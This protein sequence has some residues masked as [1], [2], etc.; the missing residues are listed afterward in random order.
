MRTPRGFS[1][2]IIFSFILIFVL[3]S[4]GGSVTEEEANNILK[5]QLALTNEDCSTAVDILEGMGRKTDNLDYIQT[6]SSAY[7][8]YT[9]FRETT[10]WTSD[11]A[12]IDASSTVN[13]F[14]S[15]VTF[16]TSA[17]MTSAT[18]SRHSNLVTA[19]E[20][21]LLAGGALTTSSHSNRLAIYGETGAQNINLQSLFMMLAQMGKYLQYYGNGNISTGS[22]GGGNPNGATNN[23]FYQYTGD[24]RT[25]LGTITA[26]PCVQDEAGSTDLTG[27]GT[28]TQ[29]RMCQ[30]I[31]LFNNIVNVV[32]NTNF[33]SNGGDL[34]SISGQVSSLVTECENA[35]TAA[36]KANDICSTR[37][38]SSCETI[39]AGDFDIIQLFFVE[40][41]EQFYQS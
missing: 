9:D 11:L 3:T 8:C 5:A 29:S 6:L 13:L 14:K 26:T 10:F 28:T 20:V 37:D 36:G 30:G 23:C 7:A 27:V 15:F 12:N 38:Q 25:L 39:A 21:L 22:K 2:K 34:S 35:L 17:T 18:D 41:F 33:P 31:V 4:C 24:A 40:V 1:M 19:N 16:S 32:A